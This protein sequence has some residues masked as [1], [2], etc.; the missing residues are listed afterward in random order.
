MIPVTCFAGRK[1]AVFGLGK[2][3]L[4]A[5]DALLAGGA[6]VIA[7][8]DNE[9]ARAPLEERAAEAFDLRFIDFVALDALVLAP[10]VPLT[11][12]EPHWTVEKARRSGVEIIGD[13]ELLV[14]ELAH[15]DTGAKMVAITGTNGKSTTTA[16]IGHVLQQCGCKVAVGGNIG[17]A[18]LSLDP[19]EAGM[20]YVLEFSSFQIDLT[21]GLKPDVAILL[22]V[23]P[24]HLDR[25]GDIETYTAVKARVFALQE[26]ED[27]AVIALDDEICRAIANELPGSGRKV[28]IAGETRVENG[29][30]AEAGR[31]Y[32]VVDGERT[33]FADLTGIVSLRGDHNGQNAAAAA[34]A[35]RALGL[36]RGEIASALA[37]FPGLSHRMEQVGRMGEV[38]FINDSK[39]TNADAAARALASFDRIFWIAGG[40]AK[41]GGIENLKEFFPKIEKAY[42]IGDAAEAFARTLDGK[43]ANEMVGTLERALEASVRDISDTGADDA[44]VLFSPAC[45][46]FDQYR[47]FELRGEAFRTAVH[48]LAGVTRSKGT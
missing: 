47:N 28:E 18:V 3:G 36:E 37:S 13:T 35:A 46:S 17:T 30:D 12:P 45:A 1:V 11:H 39:A 14:R 48:D 27:R 29:Y 32:Q 42:L 7:W 34:A 20:V 22:N 15:R 38:L 21:P 40:L 33:E 4:A 24:D 16:L 43:V 6:Q 25:H 23:S 19:P 41:S 10:G 26:P 2:S 5:V 9:A 8:D 44:V 31:L